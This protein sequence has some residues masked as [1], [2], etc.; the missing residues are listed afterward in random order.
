MLR[1]SSIGDVLQTLSVAGKLGEVF[2]QAEIHWVTRQE[3][4]PL[5]DTHPSIKKVWT[6][7]RGLKGREGFSE[8]ARLG[9]ELK[10]ERFTHV[11]DAHN[12]LRS[13]I[14]CWQLKGFANW[15][16]VFGKLKFLRRSI[17][18]WRRFLLFKF[19]INRFPKPFPGQFALLE[20]L[21]SWGIKPLAP[22]PPQLFLPKS[23]VAETALKLP[24]KEFVA[25]APSASYALKRWPVEHW[26]RLIRLMPQCRFV[27]LGGPEDQ[28]L[29]VIAQSEPDRVIDF[30][31]Q[32]TLF[33]S[34]DV[35]GLAQALVSNDTGLLHVAEQIG[36]PCIA[37]MGPAPFGYPG[38]PKTRILERE[39]G[40]RPCSKHGQGPCVN[41]EF[42]LCL[43]AIAPEEVAHE[44]RNMI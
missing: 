34:A 19:R 21:E 22:P 18:R 15:R 8:L 36:K 12:N 3:F 41:K 44:L 32:L 2:P 16:V 38:R 9:R 25:L 30:S 31:G 5:L 43:R 40:C 29:K 33:Q 13:R 42:Q 23:R 39:L 6:L 24:W 1:F 35:V 28:F 11:Y 7:K 20:P 10:R 37:L 26:I 14:L 27:I 4:A 17:Y